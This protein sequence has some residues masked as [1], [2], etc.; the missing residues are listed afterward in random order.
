V[1]FPGSCNQFLFLLNHLFFPQISRLTRCRRLP[2]IILRD[3]IPRSSLPSN[4]ALPP[5]YAP[6]HLRIRIRQEILRMCLCN[7][8]SSF[9]N[10]CRNVALGPRHCP[11]RHL[12]RSNR[13]SPA[14]RTPG[15]PQP[16]IRQTNRSMG[17]ALAYPGRVRERL[18]ILP[19]SRTT[20]RGRGRCHIRTVDER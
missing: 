14:L 10:T 6:P 19:R 9:T 18:T 16:R 7:H 4:T 17:Q 12:D 3:S 5:V 2:S 13:I 1:R 8:S 20:Y 11:R 15:S